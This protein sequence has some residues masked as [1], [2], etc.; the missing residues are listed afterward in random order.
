MP[1]GRVRASQ[2]RV[3]ALALAALLV[4]AAS[5][6][7]GGSGDEASFERGVYEY[8]L[9]KVE[10]DALR[11]IVPAGEASKLDEVDEVAARLEFSDDGWVQTWMLDGNTWT[12]DGDDSGLL[13]RD[14][15]GDFEVDGDRLVLYVEELGSTLTYEWSLDD[16]GLALKL[17]ENVAHPAASRELVFATQHT[18]ARPDD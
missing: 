11:A 1:P 9:T 4:G 18:F 14:H 3:L 15:F 7:G 12:L 17:Q 16:D 13:Q 5:A 6:C 10:K 2:V 8:N